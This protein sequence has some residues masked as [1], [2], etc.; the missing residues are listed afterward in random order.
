MF[1]GRVGEVGSL[2]G[3]LVVV[4]LILVALASVEGKKCVL[5]CAYNVL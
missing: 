1:D 3:G 4:Y 5:G 2:G